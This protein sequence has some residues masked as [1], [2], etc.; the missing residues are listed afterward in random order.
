MWVCGY[1]GRYVCT[2][3]ACVYVCLSIRPSVRPSVCPSVRMY[4]WMDGWMDVC[5]YITERE[6]QNH[7]IL[8][9]LLLLQYYSY[10][11]DF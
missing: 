3:Y 2:M 6:A 8:R 10:Y 5:S 9:I 1:V 7:Q 4:G 11:D